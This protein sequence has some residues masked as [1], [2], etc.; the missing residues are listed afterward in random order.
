MKNMLLPSI[1]FTCIIYFLLGLKPTAE[2]FFIMM[3]TLMMVAYPASS[4]GLAIAAGQSLVT[5]ATLLMTISFVFMVIFSGLLVN[6][7][8]VVSWLSWIQYFSIP[9]YGYSALHYN[10]FVGL[11]F[12]PDLNTTANNTRQGY[13]ICTG[14][15]YMT[16]QGIELS[17]WGLWKNHVALACMIVIF[18]TIAYLKLL[19]LRKYS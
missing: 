1:L 18:L 12:C 14:E 9:R 8:T 15:D 5:V 10:E 2:A 11:N 16:Y 3:F 7:K 13:A 6:L 17:P 19:F 4:M